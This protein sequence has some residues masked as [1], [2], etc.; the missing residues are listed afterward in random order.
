[1]MEKYIYLIFL[2]KKL[3]DPKQS[4]SQTYPEAKWISI[5]M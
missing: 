2:L 1:M 5:N 3:S 4:A